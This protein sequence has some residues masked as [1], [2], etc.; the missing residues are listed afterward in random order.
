MYHISVIK[1]DFL[2][3]GVWRLGSSFKAG[4]RN[5]WKILTLLVHS[6]VLEF[7]MV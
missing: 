4:V 3:S 7:S 2:S 6:A 5:S 1:G